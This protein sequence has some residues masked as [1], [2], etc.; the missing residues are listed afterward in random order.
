[1]NFELSEVPS[2]GITVGDLGKMGSDAISMGSTMRKRA[3][4]SL[5]QGAVVN[6]CGAD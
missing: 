1:M 6:I 3:Q 5:Q 2:L 4:A